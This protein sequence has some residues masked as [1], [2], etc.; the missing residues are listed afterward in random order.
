MIILRRFIICLMIALALFS[1]G[2]LAWVY[3]SQDKMIFYPEIYNQT[4]LRTAPDRTVKLEYITSAGRQTSWYVPPRA[5]EDEKAIPKTLWI[6]FNGNASLALHWSDQVKLAPDDNAGFL[7]FE[8]PGYGL[9]KGKPTRSTIAEANDAA[10][11]ALA[12]YLY[13]SPADLLSRRLRVLG[14]SLGAAVA[15]EFAATHPIDRIVL[16]APFTTMRA[17]ADRTV[18]PHLSWLLRHR[19]NNLASLET[20]L[21]RARHPRIIIIH[22]AADLAVPISMS[23]E[24]K[25]RWPDEIEL[26]EK[27][28]ANHTSIL[29]NIEVY[30]GDA[31]NPGGL[32]SLD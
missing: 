6:L 18:K 29:D 27:P 31:P 32:G 19:Y 12:R 3:H 17:M 10:V 25:K 11:A 22:G 20:I 30:M 7:L 16:A 13:V 23:R 14:Y 24:I 28:H 26:I 15:L 4:E 9:S 8:Y 1:I 21:S 2:F 5:S